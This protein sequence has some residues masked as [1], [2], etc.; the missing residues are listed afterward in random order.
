MEVGE[1]ATEV[2]DYYDL[3][4]KQKPEWPLNLSHIGREADTWFTINEDNSWEHGQSGRDWDRARWGR[5]G[6]VT[7]GGWSPGGKFTWNIPGKWRIAGTGTGTE[8]SSWKQKFVLGSDGTMTITKFGK[9]V[10]RHP[11]SP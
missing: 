8:F 10:T 6:Q 7:G 1:H 11:S 9:T 3:Y 2:E 4:Y 5:D